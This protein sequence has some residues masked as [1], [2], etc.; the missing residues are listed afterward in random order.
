[1]VLDRLQAAGLKIKLEKI[2]FFR[3][4]V[5]YLEHI[6]SSQGVATDPSKVETVA[7]W[8]CPRTVS[9]LRTF[10]GFVNYY[11]RFVEGFAQVAAP[12]HRLVTEACKGKGSNQ[13]Q[14][15]ACI[16]V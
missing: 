13:R 9:E 3:E 5:Q 2:E 6:I 4:E 8:S 12:L 10:L 1:M 11:R 15:L 14:E 7:Q 16:V